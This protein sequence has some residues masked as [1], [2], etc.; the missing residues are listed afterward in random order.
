M[1]YTRKGD[2]GTTGLFGTKDRYSKDSKVFDA[3]GTL[4]ELN[5]LLGVC[6]AKSLMYEDIAQDLKYVQECIFI[7]QAEI[8]GADKSVTDEKVEDLETRIALLEKK[9]ANPHGF[10]ISGENELS[11]LLDHA[12]AVSRRAER[13]VI[14]ISNERKVSDSTSK[15]LNRLS[16]FLYAAARYISLVNESKESSP[17]Y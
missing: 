5:S 3:L 16:S 1:L 17:S 2:N 7:A 15:F 14:A 9:I 6:R 12:R 11:A 4:D 13:R 10:V 8:A